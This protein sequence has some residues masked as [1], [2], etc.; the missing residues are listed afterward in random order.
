MIR[1]QM[2]Q[3]FFD[4]FNR[5]RNGSDGL[6]TT[7]QVLEAASVHSGIMPYMS[8]RHP[9]PDGVCGIEIFAP[10]WK[11]W[12][13]LASAPRWQT[14]V[15]DAEGAA[16]KSAILRQAGQHNCGFHEIGTAAFRDQKSFLVETMSLPAQR[17]D[18]VMNL[19]GFAV[20]LL[21]DAGEEAG[22]RTLPSRRWLDLGHGVPAE[23]PSSMLSLAA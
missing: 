14:D 13:G 20:P 3:V 5:L 16:R 11:Q 17:E 21:S 23:A 12:L 4:M 8:L 15:M 1:T 6:P 19:F 22:P 7:G 9:G 2:C 18:G 10:A